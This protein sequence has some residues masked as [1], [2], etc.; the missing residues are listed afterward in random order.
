MSI[1]DGDHLDEEGLRGSK[2]DDKKPTGD[3]PVSDWL[4]KTYYHLQKDNFQTAKI[5]IVAIPILMFTL[6]AFFVSNSTSNLIAFFAMTISIVF[7]FVSLWILC[8]ILDKDCGT[9]AM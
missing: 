4:L 3:D 2:Y 8:W 5:G 6:F 1:V 7:V 9:R